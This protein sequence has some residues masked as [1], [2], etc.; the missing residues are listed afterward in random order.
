M[1]IREAAVHNAASWAAFARDNLTIVDEC[2]IYWSKVCCF[3]N[4]LIKYDMKAII[5]WSGWK[6]RIYIK[7]SIKEL[8]ISLLGLFSCCENTDF[9]TLS[10]K[11]LQHKLLCIHMAH[12]YGPIAMF[13][14]NKS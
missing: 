3:C 10:T 4:C 13:L 1:L 8:C 6:K 7:F 12:R 9:K 14:C 11:L 5:C 2:G